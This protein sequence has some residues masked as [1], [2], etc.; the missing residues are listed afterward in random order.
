MKKLSLSAAGFVLAAMA[1]FVAPAHANLVTNGGFERGDF[2]GWTQTGETDFNGVQCPG[3]DA[4]VYAGNCSAFFGSTFSGGGI[5][6]SI[7][8]GSV[9]MTWNLSF[10]FQPDGGVPSSLTVLFGGQTLLSLMEPS[11]GDY[12]LYQFSGITTEEN[13]TLAFNFFSPVGYLF[14][15]GV[16]V[17]ASATAVPEPASTALVG[18]GLASLLFLRRRKKA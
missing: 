9:G 1:T 11:A 3:S 15:D 4:S 2:S 7:D 14:L 13:M 8:F 5:A 16:S 6:Q 10:A 12:Q 17:T 18:A